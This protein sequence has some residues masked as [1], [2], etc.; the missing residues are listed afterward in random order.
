MRARIYQPTRNA[1]QSGR[2][3]EKRWVL[4]YDPAAARKLDPLMGWTS[5]SDMDAQVQIEFDS[6]GEAETY[7]KAK[8]LDYVVEKPGAR[9]TKSKVYAD[10]FRHDRIG[11]WTH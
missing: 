4:N 9:S 6:L 3:N 5:A 10:N 11:L 7:A 1:M 8:D 2:R